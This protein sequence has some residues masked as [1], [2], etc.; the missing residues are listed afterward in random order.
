[1]C[2][3]AQRDKIATREIEGSLVLLAEEYAYQAKVHLIKR[4]QSHC[5]KADLFR[6]PVGK[7]V[8]LLSEAE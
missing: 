4:F 2:I 5:W 6:P 7:K 3:G 1:M 8:M